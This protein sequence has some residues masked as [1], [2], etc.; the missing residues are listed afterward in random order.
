MKITKAK[1]KQIIKEEL[2]LQE[3]FGKDIEM[4]NTSSDRGMK[5][6]VSR[7]I[8]ALEQIGSEVEKAHQST[9]DPSTIEHMEM[10]DGLITKLHDEMSDLLM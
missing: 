5:Q 7:M 8:S 1:L 4:P 6:K 9:R 3:M 2:S 10:I